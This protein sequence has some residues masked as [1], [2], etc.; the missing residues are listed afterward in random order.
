MVWQKSAHCDREDFSHLRFFSSKFVLNLHYCNYLHAPS[1]HMRRMSSF[2]TVWIWP[3]LVWKIRLSHFENK[4]F[5]CRWH[6][7][8]STQKTLNH[9]QKFK[10]FISWGWKGSIIPTYSAKIL[11]QHQFLEIQNKKEF[12]IWK[13]NIGL[14]VST[15]FKLSHLKIRL[16]WLFT[17]RK[18]IK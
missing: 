6:I 8:T 9:R 16:Q 10:L 4:L 7:S 14:P 17:T 12:V 5:I 1:S 11:E 3:F 18:G 2:H 15:Y 13:S